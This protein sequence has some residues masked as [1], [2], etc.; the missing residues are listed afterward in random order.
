MIFAGILVKTAVSHS[1]P[2]RPGIPTV[3]STVDVQ[4]PLQS[5]AEPMEQD[6][7]TNIRILK[8]HNLQ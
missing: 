5:V 3:D 6:L 7:A 1:Q 2:A 4:H 8:G